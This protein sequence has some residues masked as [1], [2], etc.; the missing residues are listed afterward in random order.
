MSSPSDQPIALADAIEN[1][2]KELTEASE[3]SKDKSLK[4]NVDQIELELAVD[5]MQESDASGDF[6]FK[7]F[8]TGVKAGAKTGEA[9]TSKHRI[10][11]IM[12]P[13]T[14]NGGSFQVADNNAKR[15]K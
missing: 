11:I 12:K 3:R 6:S 9:Q 2:R 10:K 5:I 14:A 8:G 15:P 7:I 1:L 13:A 4:F